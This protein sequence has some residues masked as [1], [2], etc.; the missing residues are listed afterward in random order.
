MSRTKSLTLTVM[1]V[2]AVSAAA[3][4]D[5]SAAPHWIINGTALASGSSESVLGL[6]STGNASIQVAISK[7]ETDVLCT[8]AEATETITGP[9]KDEDSNGPVFSGCSISKPAGCG[10]TNP[11]VVKPLTSELLATETGGVGLDTWSPKTGDEFVSLTISGT[12]CVVEGVYQVTGKV[13]CEAKLNV[14]SETFPCLF[15]KNSGKGLLKFGSIEADFLAHFLFLLKGTND[16]KNWGVA[17][18]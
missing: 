7:I 3:A 14:E 11:I 9:N 4:S 8:S 2:L 10:L 15:N 5:A 17:A 6:L 18:P 12:A 1:A 16:G 13:Q